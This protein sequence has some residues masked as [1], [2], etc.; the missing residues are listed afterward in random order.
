[1][2]THLHLSTVL[3]FGLAL[4][5]SSVAGEGAAKGIEFVRVVPD[6]MHQLKVIRVEAISFRIQKSAIGRIA[7][8]EDAS[9]NVLSPFS[10][11]VTRVIGKIGDHVN[12]GDNLLELDSP[13]QLQPQ[14]DLITAQSARN[15]ALSQL[16]L[17]QIL[18]KRVRDLFNGKAA[19][20]KDLQ[21]AE[22]QLAGAENDL[23]SADTAVETARTRLRIVGR[24]EAEILALAGC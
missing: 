23:R 14:N 2:I 1:M 7:F 11:R 22:A 18:E 8:N 4:T 5:T 17:A 20:L 12:R 21:L 19:A 9:T 24:T 6:Q 15:K 10:G 16:S 3:F 13:E